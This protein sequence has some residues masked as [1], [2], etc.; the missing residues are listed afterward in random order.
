MD[1]PAGKGIRLVWLI[2]DSAG[3]EYRNIFSY[4]NDNGVT[5]NVEPGDVTTWAANLWDQADNFISNAYSLYGVK[6]EGIGFFAT[7]TVSFTPV[8][9]GGDANDRLPNQVAG[10]V[11]GYTDKKRGI[12][13]KY[14]VGVCEDGITAGLVNAGYLAALQNFGDTWI[15]P[16]DL[17]TY[18]L[19]AGLYDEALT[20][21]YPIKA[22][23][24]RTVPATQRR[25]RAGVG[26]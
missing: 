20:T 16:F 4:Y 9:Q 3:G 1:V 10:L 19:T 23:V 18:S 25:R 14:L 6:E 7:E 5:V 24:A 21:W 12:M 22:T 2:R 17:G 11:T 13:K 26:A 15:E 8:Y